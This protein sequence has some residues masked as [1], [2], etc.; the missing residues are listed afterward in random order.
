MAE[1]TNNPFEPGGTSIFDANSPKIITNNTNNTNINIK[2]PFDANS[3]KIT[4]NNNS[5]NNQT[6]PNKSVKGLIR[7][8]ILRYPEKPISKMDDYLLITSLE[9]YPPGIGSKSNDVFIDFRSGDETNRSLAD[10]DAQGNYYRKE[11]DN[12]ILPIPRAISDGQ[13]AS[14][15][16][17]ALSPMMAGAMAAGKSVVEGQDIPNGL[18]GAKNQIDDLLKSSTGQEGVK[19]AALAMAAK[20]LTGNDENSVNNLV[21]RATGKIINPNVE[22]LFNGVTLRSGFNFQFD[23]IPR[24]TTEGENIKQII[25]LFKK[26]MLPSKNSGIGA[27]GFFIKGPKVFSLRFMRGKEDHPFLNKFKICALTNMSVDYSGSGQYASYWDATPV[28]M[29]M[30]LQFQ[31]LSPI[32]SEDYDGPFGEGGVGY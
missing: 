15:G 28:H 13:S 4:T 23:L 10:K 31:E 9:Y 8:K 3:P 5:T 7:G 14:W 29:V 30:N 1:S 12:V 2:N 20:A 19:T 25:R 24:N 21:S 27:K 22:L 11:L 16:T 6:N 17:D 18:A 26:S 32:Y